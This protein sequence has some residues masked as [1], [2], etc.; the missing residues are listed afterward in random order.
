MTLELILHKKWFHLIAQGKKN[1]E[2][3][4]LKQYWIKRILDKK[5]RFTQVRFRNGYQKDAPTML[6][7]IDKIIVGIG[8]KEFGAPE[9][10]DC[11]NIHLGKL[12]DHENMP[13]HKCIYCGIITATPDVTCYASP[14]PLLT[15]F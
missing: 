11:I 13:E 14:A 8:N 6:F 10:K 2:Y 5:H 7:F 15:N 3:R 1:V 4:E 9:K 12:I